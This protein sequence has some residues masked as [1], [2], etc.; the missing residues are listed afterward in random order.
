MRTQTSAGLVCLLLVCASPAALGVEPGPAGQV[1]GD[2][3][4]DVRYT[5][6][7]EP[8][9]A[10]RVRVTAT[11]ERPRHVAGLSVRPPAGT[12]VRRADGL[13]RDGDRWRVDGPGT[14]R[15]TYTV[16]VGL[17]TT[18]GQR[19]ADTDDWT[20]LARQELS[21]RARWR[22]HVGPRPRW[23]ESLALAPG[24][25]GVAGTTAAYIGPHETATATV[26]GDRI[27]LVVPA[28][29]DL[30]PNRTAVLHSISHAK[31]ASTAGRDH[32]HVRVFVAPNGLAS[33]GYAPTN[34]EPDVIV[35]AG[36]PV[37][38]PVNV[39]V[40]EY[41][42]TRQ[43]FAVTP[44]MAWLEEGSADYHTAALTYAAGDIGRDRFRDRVTTERY[45]TA[46]L[47]R[48]DSWDG[49]GPQYHKGAR[50]VAAID[51]RIR[52]A[53][54]GRRTF[55]AVLDRLMRRDDR[56]TLALFAKT[57]SSVARADL[58][59][60]VRGA[61]TGDAPTVPIDGL[62]DSGPRRSGSADTTERPTNAAPSVGSAA[63]A[64]NGDEPAAGVDTARPVTDRH[65]EWTVLGTLGMLSVLL[66]RRQR[67]RERP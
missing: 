20:L 65:G 42:H 50:V 59:A 14:A 15:L 37:H 54:E 31:R 36:E 38:S 30:R 64:T 32:D 28:A 27:T 7:R 40:H 44:A 58:G 46:D 52:Q 11:I 33:G 12:T 9:Q 16:P 26:D 3:A 6:A 8:A 25:R 49:P 1:G 48:P 24:Q 67:R 10:G 60:F 55:E 45:E 62:T 61:V 17:A 43:T 57:V 2:S 4:I 66:A 39:W 35:N 22:W 56:V 29:A 51:A 23:N 18:F 47:T 41:R 53:T 34:G 19:T 5:V 13:S 21:L 63:T